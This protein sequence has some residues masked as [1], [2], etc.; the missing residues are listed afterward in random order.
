LAGKYTAICKNVPESGWWH[1]QEQK[2][3]AVGNCAF[4]N[5]HIIKVL[6]SGMLKLPPL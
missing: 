4:K 3:V 2:L 6:T 5:L 1:W